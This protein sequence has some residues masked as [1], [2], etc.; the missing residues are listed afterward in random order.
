MSRTFPAATA[1]ALPLVTSARLANV[2]APQLNR[3]VSPVTTVTSAGEQPS[4]SAAIWANVVWWP[5]PCVVSPVATKTRP[6]GST[7]TWA[8]SYGPMP[9]PLH[10]AAD[11]EPEVPALGARGRLLGP[12][13]PRADRVQRHLEARPGSS[14]CRSASGPPSWNVSP[15]SHGN[16]SGWMR[17][18]RRTS[19]GSRPSSRAM[20]PMTRSITKAPW[21]RPA[22]R[23]G[24]VITLFV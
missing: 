8:P 20:S 18:R 15:T 14:R 4:A 2:P 11:P 19:A 24:V 17:F 21:G 3:P 10:V 9:G 1:T 6:L 22:P 16:S 13:L 23:Y 5:W 12:E 7:R